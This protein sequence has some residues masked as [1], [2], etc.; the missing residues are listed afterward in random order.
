MKEDMALAALGLRARIIAATP[1]AFRGFDALAVDDPGA[2][3]RFKA[4][5]LAY[6]QQ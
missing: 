4:R 1:A 2:G 5:R 3:G 6:H